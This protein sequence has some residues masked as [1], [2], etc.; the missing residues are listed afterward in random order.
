MSSSNNSTQGVDETTNVAFH[1]MADSDEYMESDSALQSFCMLVANVL[2]A[3]IPNNPQR[4][5]PE[6]GRLAK[7]LGSEFVGM[8]SDTGKVVLWGSRPA[9][10]VLIPA[11]ENWSYTIYSN[12]QHAPGPCRLTDFQRL[13]ITTDREQGIRKEVYSDRE[14]GS[15][16]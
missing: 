9:F 10:P 12:A 13:R 8:M 6:Q 5:C 11:T 16:H 1:A 2:T 3:A 7:R 4:D 14:F 15:R